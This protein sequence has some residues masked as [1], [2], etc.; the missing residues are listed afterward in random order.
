M[1]GI[2]SAAL[3]VAKKEYEDRRGYYGDMGSSEAAAV[4][5]HV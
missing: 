5:I 3:G 4:D 1:L 2:S